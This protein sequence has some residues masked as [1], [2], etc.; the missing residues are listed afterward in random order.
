MKKELVLLCFVFLSLSVVSAATVQITIETLPVHEVYLYILD[1]G[2]KYQSLQSFPS[3]VT[4]FDG[5][6]TFN[7][8]TNLHEF[9]IFVIVK[10]DG[11]NVFSERMDNQAMSAFIDLVVPLE[12]FVPSSEKEE[13]VASDTNET[14]AVIPIEA[15]EEESIEEIIEEGEG[16]ITGKSIAQ[17]DG[18]GLSKLIYIL[19][20]IVLVG[21][22]AGFIAVRKMKG[23][24]NSFFHSNDKPATILT[25]SSI[26]DAE[27][28]IEQAEREIR[29]I[30]ATNEKRSLAQQK[31]IDA[32][33]ELEEVE[34]GYKDENA[35]E[36]IKE[37]DEEQQ[38]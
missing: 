14:E 11:L 6:V 21:S 15:E 35:S 37:S 13:E 27:K 1:A 28:K 17:N 7:Y 25:D 30:K 9:G 19:V 4:G 16:G 18:D 8:T 38:N 10:K 34:V 26:E 20:V 23:S 36:I 22:I 33:K 32:K 5:K 3:L 24:N 29:D 31:F 2:G 12:G